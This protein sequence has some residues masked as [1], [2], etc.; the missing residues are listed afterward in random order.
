MALLPTTVKEHHC[1]NYNYTDISGHC[2]SGCLEDLKGH[3]CS[4]RG[5][6]KNPCQGSQICVEENLGL[7]EISSCYPEKEIRVE[8][9]NIAYKRRVFMKHGL[10]TEK[11]T[12]GD[13][14][15]FFA[16]HSIHPDPWIVIDLSRYYMI[17]SIEMYHPPVQLN[18]GIVGLRIVIS[19]D[20]SLDSRYRFD[21]KNFVAIEETVTSEL[22]DVDFFSTK[23]VLNLK[24]RFVMLR[25]SSEFIGKEPI[26]VREVFVRGTGYK[27]YS[28]YI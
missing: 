17:T 5:E 3:G 12:D 9:G 28:Y 18:R 27:G 21:E 7:I 19:K 25:Q 11:A 2:M 23:N 15:S 14:Y 4:Q 1:K 22:S 16:T 13:I 24:G 20:F 26:S 8:V 6:S 10:Y